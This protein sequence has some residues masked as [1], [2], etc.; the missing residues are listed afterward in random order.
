MTHVHECIYK[1]YILC[2]YIQY[3]NPI[4][5]HELHILY[6]NQ[7]CVHVC[8]HVHECIHKMCI[9]C[10]VIQPIADRVAQHLEIISKNFQFSTRRTRILMGFIF[11]YL[12]IIVN[13]MGR[14]LVRWKFFRNNLK[15]RFHPIC[16]WLYCV[17]T[18]NTQIKFMYMNGAYDIQIKCVYSLYTF[19][20]IVYSLYTFVYI[21]Y[22]HKVHVYKCSQQGACIQMYTT[23]CMYTN[24]R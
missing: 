14:I 8:T 19:V 11:C 18:Y 3:T 24:V 10:G 12:V 1:L 9:P 17:E 22:M 15:M 20:Y 2:W 7:I 5:V 4:H 13:P 16:N 6:T 23:R 21:V